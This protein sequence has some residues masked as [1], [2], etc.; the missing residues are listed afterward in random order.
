MIMYPDNP[1]LFGKNINTKEI[2][3]TEPNTSV[4]VSSLL[5]NLSLTLKAK[6]YSRKLAIETKII[7][8]TNS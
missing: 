1:Q 8:I 4:G 6:Q 2:I 7:W 3:E 5:A